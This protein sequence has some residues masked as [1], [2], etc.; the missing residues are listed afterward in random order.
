MVRHMPHHV[1]SYYDHHHRLYHRIIW[2]RY[3]YPVCYS[4]G[5]R[6]VFRSVFPYYHRKYVFVSLGGWWP[7]HY[8][9]VRYYWYGWHPYAW[10]GY[11]PV[12]QEVGADTYKYYTYNYY[13][14][15]ENSYTTST[16][17]SAENEIRPV[18]ESTWADVRAKL[19]QQKAEPASQTLADTRFEEGVK[20]FEAGDFSAAAE[21]FAAAMNLAP[22]D[23]I[24]PFAYAQALFANQQYTRAAEVLRGVLRT[25]SPEQEGVFYPRGL[26]G[27]DDVLF[28]QV[29]KLID[30]LD[31]YEYDADMQLLLGYHLLGIGETEYARGPLER[32]SQDQENAEA[33]RMLLRLL[34][35]IETQA[36]ATK[37]VEAQNTATSPVQQGTAASPAQGTTPPALR[38]ENAANIA[39][40]APGVPDAPGKT[41]PG[42]GT[43]AT[44]NGVTEG[45]VIRAIPKS[46]T[47]V[48]TPPA[49]R[50]DDDAKPAI[51]R[52][53]PGTQ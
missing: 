27:N 52:V 9:S 23:V 43:E 29:Q 12:A 11:Y 41:T 53:D 35:K 21:K 47:G 6:L 46:G 48:K 5:P 17:S 30:R 40:P 39:S 51:Q 22:N 14:N 13:L 42:A 25:V 38:T 50:E 20:S 1:H 15:G 32:A 10:Y 19:E 37:A 3:Y 18:D 49:K 33:A 26:Y 16:Y 7:S 28:A 36:A 4:F 31:S 45:T 8:D 44:V 2:P 24:L 34:E